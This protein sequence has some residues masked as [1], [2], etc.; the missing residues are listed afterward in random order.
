MV[1]A[2]SE[3]RRWH[4]LALAVRPGSRE[5]AWA[6][7]G[8][9][10]LAAQQGDLSAAVPLLD[11]AAAVARDLPDPELAA[12]VTRAPGTVAFY[13]GHNEA[14]LELFGTAL[15]R[16]EETRIGGPQALLCYSRLAPHCLVAL[17]L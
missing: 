9:G 14:A 17:D 7:Y 13:A 15:A 2:F 5:N 11:R 8:A 12:H 16:V 6:S 1:G 4:E 10:A 3:A